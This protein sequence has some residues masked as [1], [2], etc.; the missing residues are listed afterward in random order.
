MTAAPPGMDIVMRLP[1][2]NVVNWTGR[3]SAAV[4]GGFAE[5]AIA[6]RGAGVVGGVVVHNG[7]SFP[8][9]MNN[10]KGFEFLVFIEWMEK[11]NEDDFHV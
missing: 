4:H 6:G 10:M 2:D 9:P 11:L 8:H 7:F 5:A 1:K 3:V